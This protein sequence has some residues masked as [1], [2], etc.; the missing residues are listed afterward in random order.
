[1]LS[2]TRKITNLIFAL[3]FFQKQPV[4]EK[5]LASEY[6]VYMTD[7]VGVLVSDQ[8]IVIADRVNANASE[9]VFRVSFN[10]KGGAYDKNRTYRLVI[11]NGKDLPQEIPFTIDIAFA[12]DFGFDW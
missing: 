12:D 8:K 4:G 9:R 10:L 6:T 3:E 2:E 5:V 1:M 7:D 11:T